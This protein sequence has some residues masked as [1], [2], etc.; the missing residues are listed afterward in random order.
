MTRILRHTTYI[1][2]EI[3]KT[4]IYNR[5]HY[6]KLKLTV[7]NEIRWEHLVGLLTPNSSWCSSWYRFD[8][9]LVHASQNLLLPIFFNLSFFVVILIWYYVCRLWKTRNSKGEHLYIRY[10]VNSYQANTVFLKV[11]SFFWLSITVNLFLESAGWHE[12]YT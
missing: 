9:V 7:D 5:Y 1:S 8:Y 10:C 4:F 3:L 12:M 11:F 6:D 2:Y